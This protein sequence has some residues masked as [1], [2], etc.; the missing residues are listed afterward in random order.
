[1]SQHNYKP[2]LIKKENEDKT[3]GADKKE[4]QIKIELERAKNY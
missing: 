3:D 2:L 4:L 1:L